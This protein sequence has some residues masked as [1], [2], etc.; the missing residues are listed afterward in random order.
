MNLLADESTDAPVVGRLRADGHQVDHVAEMAPGTPD[1]S[2]LDRANSRNAILM[3]AD[4]DFGELV[5][6][7]R[8]VSLGVALVRLPGLS[9]PLKA[10]LVADALQTHG[11]EIQHAFSVIT[12]GMVR[13]RREV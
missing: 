6:R 3:T 4:K 11:E 1:E 5:F 12:P 10:R 9:P 2:V 13:I 7:Q 8:K